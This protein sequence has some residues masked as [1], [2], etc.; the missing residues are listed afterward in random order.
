MKTRHIFAGTVISLAA[1]TTAMAAE[2]AGELK[3]LSGSAS[4]IADHGERALVTGSTVEAGDLVR[5]SA[6]GEAQILM[7]DG[8]R[9]VVGP[10]SSMKID[11]YEL[12]GG[13]AADVTAEVAALDGIFRLISD[14][15]GDK[16]YSID[17]PTASIK[18]S[19]T[20]F[21]FTV[22]KS[23]AT[24]LLLIEG[25][26]TMCGTKGARKCETVAS[27]CALLRT[28]DGNEVTQVGVATA[29]QAGNPPGSGDAA[30]GASGIVDKEILENFRYQR[31]QAGLR[32]EFRVA[33]KPCVEGATGGVA[34]AALAQPG[35]EIPVV[36]A[37]P[38][39]A[40]VL[41]C[42][43]ACTKGNSPDA[44]NHTN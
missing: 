33:G 31:S 27:P 43:I 25:E 37:V 6:T 23:G 7:R 11:A 13:A 18:M 5:T 24:R 10:N 20:A 29:A 30:G 28:E 2:T 1:I 41:Y 17:T 40:A 36:I 39:A 14:G 42:I 3:A 22:D 16:G 34:P 19:G 26:V 32:D 4:A 12:K 44:T 8:T 15:S 35:I 9:L 38:V 21:D